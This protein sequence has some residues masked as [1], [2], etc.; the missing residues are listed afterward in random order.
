MSIRP[1]VEKELKTQLTFGRGGQA[2][3][4]PA[5]PMVAETI[6]INRWEEDALDLLAFELWQRACCPEGKADQ[7]WAEAEV[8]SHASCL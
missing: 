8:W 1:K 6:E 3:E 7:E 4:A 2:M 5:M